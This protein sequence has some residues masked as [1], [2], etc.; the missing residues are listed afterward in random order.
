MK[1]RTMPTKAVATRIATVHRL[2]GNVYGDCRRKHSVKKVSFSRDELGKC[3]DN[4]AA[5]GSRSFFFSEGLSFS[6]VVNPCDALCGIPHLSSVGLMGILLDVSS[7]ALVH[8]D[9]QLWKVVGI[10]LN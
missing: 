3:Y 8:R 5:V 7:H 9:I 4:V 2:V 6:F 10:H 1:A